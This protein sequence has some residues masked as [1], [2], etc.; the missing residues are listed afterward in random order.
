MIGEVVQGDEAS[1]VQ[2]MLATL[3]LTSKA[4]Q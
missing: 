1:H 2:A 3:G 4:L